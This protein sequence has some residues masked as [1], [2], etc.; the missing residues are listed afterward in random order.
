[1]KR[2]LTILSLLFALAAV[3]AFAQQEILSAKIPFGF[4]VKGQALAAGEYEVNRVAATG[5]WVI[6]SADRPQGVFFITTPEAYTANAQPKLV[7]H[8]YGDRYFLAQVWTPS[9]SVSLP[10]SRQELQIRAAV[11]RPVVVALLIKR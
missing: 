8:R 7:F 6:R 10:E 3:P 2:A 11:G 4:A 9:L 5:S 1:M